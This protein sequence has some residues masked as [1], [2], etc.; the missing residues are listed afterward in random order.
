MYANLIPQLT[1][2]IFSAIL[3]I[4]A[5]M[6]VFSR[7][8]VRGVLFLVLAFFASS[9]L[10]M[11]LEGEFL[12][13]VLIFVYVGAV[14]T[15]FLFVVMMLN[16][17]TAPRM[18]GLVRYLPIFAVVLALLVFL[19]IKVI[20]PSYFP[21]Q[22][23]HVVSHPADYSNTKQLGMLLYTQF[24]YPFELAAVL[25]LVAIIAAISLAFRGPRH[26]KAQ[27]ITQQL[28]V[29]PEDRVRLIK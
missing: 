22:V 8:P 14:M 12:A 4:S 25:L 19:M 23:Y 18:Q 15:L 10:W 9:V 1:F 28:A 6:V 11:L 5:V 29:K 13:L 17:D 3:L 21:D 7:Q 27:R 16:L 26:R 24:A 2:Y 20:N